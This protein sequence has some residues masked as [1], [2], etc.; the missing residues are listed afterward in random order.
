MT[1]ES[2]M[3]I[4][5]RWDSPLTSLLV[6]SSVATLFVVLRWLVAAHRQLGRFV[7]AGSNFAS[8]GRVP[9]DLPVGNGAG[10]D[11][12]FYYRLALDPF[13]LAHSAFG[14]RLD[15]L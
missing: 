8:P 7:V 1:I 9:K 4:K 15:S 2:Q 10:Y 13:D 6:A 11:G 3:T 5:S 12:Q 14:I